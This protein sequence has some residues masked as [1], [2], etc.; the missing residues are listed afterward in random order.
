MFQASLQGAVV[1]Y[2]SPSVRRPRDPDLASQK[3]HKQNRCF[4]LKPLLLEIL[5]C[6]KHI[7][8]SEDLPTALLM[9]GG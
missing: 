5:M 2:R 8:S 6:S 9:R 4:F 3:E 7:F 1:S